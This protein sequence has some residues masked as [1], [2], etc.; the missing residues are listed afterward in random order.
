MCQDPKRG[1][2]LSKVVGWMQNRSCFPAAAFPNK[3]HKKM[4]K[5]GLT[6]AKKKERVSFH[7]VNT[8]GGIHTLDFSF[9]YNIMTRGA[10][11][12]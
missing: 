10:R 1:T 8:I 9:H 2:Q 5:S 7:F 12:V 3:N 11:P 4:L 6:P